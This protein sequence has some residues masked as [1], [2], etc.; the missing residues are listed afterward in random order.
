MGRYTST[1]LSLSLGPLVLLVVSA[2]AP[3]ISPTKSIVQGLVP[4]QSSLCAL[5]K[6]KA[7]DI[8]KLPLSID[9]AVL[10]MTTAGYVPWTTG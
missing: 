5:S 4:A 7:S 1:P 9:V 10:Q 6:R 3:D 8:S 2:R